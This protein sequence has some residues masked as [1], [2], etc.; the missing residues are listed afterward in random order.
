MQLKEAT[1]RKVHS[2]KKKVRRLPSSRPKTVQDYIT[3]FKK[4]GL[5][6]V[7]DVAKQKPYLDKQGKRY[8]QCKFL[9]KNGGHT[10][11]YN[12]IQSGNNNLSRDSKKEN[13][14]AGAKAWKIT[15]SSNGEDRQQH[16]KEAETWRQLCTKLGLDEIHQRWAPDCVSNDISLSADGDRWCL[17]QLKSALESEAG[18]IDFAMR[19][20]EYDGFVLVGISFRKS[21]DGG[22]RISQ[23]FITADSSTLPNTTFMPYA[24]PMKDDPYKAIRFRLDVPEQCVAA[25]VKLIECIRARAVHTLHDTFFSLKLNN[26]MSITQRT[27]LGGFLKLKETLPADVEMVFEGEKNTT[28]DFYLQLGQQRVTVSAKTPGLNHKKADGSYSGY[29]FDK[30]AAPEHHLCD[31][32][33]VIYNDERRFSVLSASAV[34]G[35]AGTS[36]QWRKDGSK[37]GVD[38]VVRKHDALPLDEMFSFGPQRAAL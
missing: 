23:A 30:N 25:K 33:V 9:L 22:L 8:S 35:V 27:E 13:C 37:K 1:A 5:D 18:K 26:R 21:E 16:F 24:N 14:A 2:D 29:Y 28:V 12:N 34:Y 32:V 17:T 11:R 20:G 15:R 19:R 31:F 38:Y 6:V 10:A 7:E 36:F 3:V 4:L